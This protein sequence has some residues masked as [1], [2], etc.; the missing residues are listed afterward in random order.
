METLLQDLRFAGRTLLKRP[1]FTF[2]AV[3]TLALGIGANTAIFSVV[4]SVLLADLPFGNPERLTVVWA[5]NPELAKKVGLPDMLPVSPG[6]FYDWKTAGAFEKMAMMRADRLS[7][8]GEGEPEQLSLVAVTGELFQALGTPALAGRAI[9]PGD[10]E[11]SKP[12]VVVLSHAL[13][14][15]RFGGDRSVIGKTV[16]L[17]GNPLTVAGVMPPD[18]VFPRGAEMP[19]GFGFAA[20]PDGW[21]PMAMTPEQRQHRG[22]RSQV[23]IGL[24]KPGT[25][26]GAAQAEMDA[27]SDRIEKAYPEGRGW[28]SRVEPLR[29]QLVGNVRPA[30]LILLGAVGVVLL[31]A[32]VNVANLLLAQAAARQKEIAV[33]TALG[34]GRVRMVR[35]LLT[36]SA[37]LALLGGAFGILLAFWGLR[38]L[39]VWIPDNVPVSSEIPLDGRVLAF[40]LTATFL[41]GAL[42]GLVPAFQMTR[43]DL[44]ETLRDGTR[45]GSG[46]SRGGRTRS[47]LVVL[48]TALAVL[49]VV[50]AGL[51]MRSF[52]SLLAV[53]PGFRPE[54]VLTLNVALPATKYEERAKRAAFADAVVERLRGIPGV[55][56]AG[57]VSNL[58]MSGEENIDAVTI[59][60]AP[61]PKPDEIPLADYRSVTPGYFEALGVRLLQGRVFNQGDGAQAPLAAVIDQTMAQAYW[62][63]TDPVGKR[64]SRGLPDD[65]EEPVWMTVV[66]VVDNVRH[67]GLHVDP[68]P[69]MYFPQAQ[70]P[71]SSMY[72]TVRTSRD[73]EGLIADAR[74][75]VFAVD[76]DQPVTKIRTMEQVVSESLAGRRFNM[77]L[78]GIF[79]G[80]A[81]VLA[82]VGIYGITSYS[83]V[84]RTREMGL[85]M[86][87]GAQPWTVLALVLREAGKLTALGLAAG[88]VLA[89]VATRVMSSLLFG[90]GSTDPTTFAAV[91]VGLAVVALLA[92]YMPGR[93][94]TQVDPMVALRAD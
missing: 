94:A 36:E 45:A 59:E 26:I 72:F 61:P 52:A 81:L 90:V 8:T 79:A 5:S 74:A 83:V 31:V 2:I 63:D 46:T 1:A 17:D 15:R 71:A 42:A 66:G 3:L 56:A 27:I 47:L 12:T 65:N 75:A 53:D 16:R 18:F 30:L 21:Y 67:S 60:G 50:G 34:A 77:V 32:C 10:D 85:R 87:L 28:R 88:L 22:N 70:S 43:P 69:Q 11:G 4:N 13:W 29:E 23:A 89:L 39:A 76:R 25:G 35:Q 92:A 68:R 86:A 82:A 41:A 58:P 49:L 51:L 80:L 93:R 19:S 38:A 57:M 9:Q 14:Q 37:L 91:A 54:G 44:A 73:P 20:E 78:L 40:A 24:L 33:R 6:D 84:Q 7:L 62:P 48:E 55:T 64:F